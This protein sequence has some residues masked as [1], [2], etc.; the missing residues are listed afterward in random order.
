[1]KK[2]VLALASA[3]LVMACAGCGG[4]SAPTAV[5]GEQESQQSDRLVSVDFE[6][7]PIP[8]TAAQ[9]KASGFTD[10]RAEHDVLYCQSTKP[11]FLFGVPAQKAQ[12]GLD[13]DDNFKSGYA[14]LGQPPSLSGKRLVDLTYRSARFTFASATYD[15]RCV[16]AYRRDKEGYVTEPDECAKPGNIASLRVALK[17][18]GW[19]GM[20]WRKHGEL[21]YKQGVPLE[22]TVG[23]DYRSDDF[24]QVEPADPAQVAQMLD[25]RRAE[26]QAATAEA[27]S[28]ADLVDAMK[29]AQ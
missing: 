14:S 25:A 26:A 2:L 13:A 1:M 21:F 11:T 8:G 4:S 9:A 17:N 20:G 16:A 12:V 27:S 5:A 18:A 6:G 22:V 28:E 24:L 15:E 19:V 23:R 7:V 10:C 3:S 29:T